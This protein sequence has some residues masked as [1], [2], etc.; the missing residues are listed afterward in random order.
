MTVHELKQQPRYF[1]CVVDGSKTFEV[2]KNDRDY[3][4]GDYLLLR[5]W[6]V[7]GLYSGRETLVKITYILD[8][9][10]YCKEGY[11]VLGFHRL[12]EI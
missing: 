5:E 8:S 4:V 3:K 10:D 7:A 6:S 9:P 11:V 12:Q 2:R 1:D